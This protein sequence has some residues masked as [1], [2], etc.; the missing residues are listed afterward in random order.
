MDPIYGHIL[1]VDDSPDVQSVLS[2]SLKAEGHQ[3]SVAANGHDALACL[4]TY[5]INLVITD[6]MMP[7]MNGYEL[8]AAMKSDPQLADIPVVVISAAGNLDD[9]V[10]SIEL[11]AEDYI[12]KPF[13]P[14]LLKA[15]IA[16]SLQRQFYRNRERSYWEQLETMYDELQQAN[17]TKNEFIAL[18]AHELRVPLSTLWAYSELLQRL[19]NNEEQREYLDNMQFSL[20]RMKTLVADLDDISRL[21]T[22]NLRLE[23]ERVDVCRVINMVQETMRPVLA[24]KGQRLLADLPDPLPAVWADQA[25][26]IQILTNLVENAAKYSPSQTVI[27]ITAV[28]APNHPFYLQIS[29]HDQGPGIQPSDQKQLFDKFYRSDQLQVQDI[30]GTGLGLNIAKSLVERLGGFIWLDSQIA[31][32]SSFHFTLP[33]DNALDQ[34]EWD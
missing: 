24:Q 4:Q 2:D 20:D 17:E 25:R 14:T 22:G 27:E 34:L 31:Q 15:R 18:V 28:P 19:D 23:L 3:V 32:G 30:P 8:L 5:E 10:R 9:A 13:Q 26:V 6:I 33:L 11:G 7:E 29:V 12:A 16:A 1:V 21:E